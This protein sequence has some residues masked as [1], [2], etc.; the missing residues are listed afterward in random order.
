MEP[1]GEEVQMSD[2]L[3]LAEHSCSPLFEHLLVSALTTAVRSLPEKSW[4]QLYEHTEGSLIHMT[5][6]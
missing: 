1:W 4:E 6:Y 5:F 3:S 2:A